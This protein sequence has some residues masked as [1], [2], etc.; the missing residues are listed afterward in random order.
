MNYESSVT[1][2]HK[3]RNMQ[4]AL[5]DHGISTRNQTGPPVFVSVYPHIHPHPHVLSSVTIVVKMTYMKRCSTVY[6]VHELVLS[7]NKNGLF[8]LL[9]ILFLNFIRYKIIVT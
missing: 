2:I 4:A 5:T 7:Q 8:L 1:A 6:N 3:S 9:T